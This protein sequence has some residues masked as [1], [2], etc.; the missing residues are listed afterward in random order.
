MQNLRQV[1]Q[2]VAAGV[3][4]AAGIP[5]ALN[6]FR[7]LH[8]HG[9]AKARAA[10]FAHLAETA[11]GT[12][13]FDLAVRAATDAVNAEPDQASHRRALALYTAQRALAAPESLEP[14]SV[15]R[16]QLILEEA[17]KN[18]QKSEEVLLALAR[19]HML[20]GHTDVAGRLFEQIVQAYPKSGRALMYQGD[21]QFKSGE[22]DNAIATLTQAVTLD[23]SLV[24]AKFALGQVRLARKE[25]DEALP[26]LETA[27]RELP[28]S[29]QAALAFG[30][31]LAAK[32]QWPEAQKSLERA[33]ALDPSLVQAHAILGDV[34]IK[35][36]QIEAAIG[37]YRIAWE[38]TRD[39][40]AFRKIGR[41]YLQLGAIEAAG[42]VFAQIR[43]LAPDEPEPHLIVGIAASTAKQAEVAKQSWQRCI[44]LA[45]ARE[46]WAAVGAKCK[47]LLAAGGAPA[48][49]KKPKSP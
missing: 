41:V 15:L 12:S 16:T 1:T 39:L 42:T 24:Q 27:A 20:R 37:S 45:E 31:V 14:R 13:D 7:R 11:A 4:I 48:P 17:V 33:L 29:G 18:E 9:L 19:I 49:A 5:L 3:V 10:G 28:K 2:F 23:N 30:R 36:R 22:L 35:N 21:L 46:E 43:D 26:W 34:Y 6:E 40:E 47:E 44:Q 25:H 38:K 8:E 32:E